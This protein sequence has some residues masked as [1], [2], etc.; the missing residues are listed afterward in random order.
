MELH[1]KRIFTTI[2]L[3]SFL[4]LL[5]MSCGLFC[6][7][8]CGGCGPSLGPQEIR[9]QSFATQTVNKSNQEINITEFGPYAETFV[10]LRINE[11]ENKAQGLVGPSESGS[12]G[13]A[14]ACSPLPPLSENILSLIQIIN[15][16][17]FTS[18]EGTQ[19]SVG[20]N[21]TTLFGM[22]H[23]YGPGLST[24]RDFI[25]PGLRL[26]FADLYKIGLLEDPQQELNLKFTIRIRFD[27]A[28]EFLLTDQTLNVR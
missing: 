24:I 12:T 23:F 10:T 16:K 22:S 4:A 17:E 19:F 1:G 9:V 18:S 21:L 27:D 6:N 26:T 11:V 3:F 13:L 25:G 2:C 15:E 8:S 28:Q 7:D 20:E 5:P 14:Y